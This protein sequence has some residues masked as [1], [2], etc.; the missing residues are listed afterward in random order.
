MSDDTFL[1]RDRARQR[2]PAPTGRSESESISARTRAR[3]GVRRNATS[4][5]PA[6]TARPRNDSVAGR[7]DAVGGWART[8]VRPSATRIAAAKVAM[9]VEPDLMTRD[10][11]GRPKESQENWPRNR[12]ETSESSVALD[13]G[14]VTEI[15]WLRVRV[16]PAPSNGYIPVAEYSH[17][18]SRPLRSFTANP[19]GT[20][21]RFTSSDATRV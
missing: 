9:T 7:S 8:T 4:T 16:A 1:L 2:R 15:A 6:T 13:Y 20:T 11:I 3:S 17:R 21:L 14:T 5:S 10:C 18:C 19:S 12:A